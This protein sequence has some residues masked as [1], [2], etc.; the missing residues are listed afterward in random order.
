MQKYTLWLSQQLNFYNFRTQRK[1]S[2]LINSIS[3]FEK[4]KL[5]ILLPILYLLR[6]IIKC[7]KYIVEL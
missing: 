5:G 6:P 2:K 4:A 1:L 3:P 7:Q